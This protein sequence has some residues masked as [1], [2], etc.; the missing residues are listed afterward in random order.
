MQ[1]E[2]LKTW[3]R[4]LCLTLCPSVSTSVKWV[5]QLIPKASLN[6]FRCTTSPILE[7]QGL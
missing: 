2:S 3:L 6:G 7:W 1:Q 4:G 5:G